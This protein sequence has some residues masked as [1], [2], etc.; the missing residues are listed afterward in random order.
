MKLDIS[1][2][3]TSEMTSSNVSEFRYVY[4][5]YVHFPI[6]H[7]FYPLPKKYGILVMKIMKHYGLKKKKGGMAELPNESII[8]FRYPCSYILVDKI[9]FILVKSELNS[10]LRDVD[11]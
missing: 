3:D 10:N 11:F 6:N 4:F 2:M 8:H 1:E 7:P 9:F 5:R